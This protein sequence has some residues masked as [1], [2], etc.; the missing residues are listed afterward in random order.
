MCLKVLIAVPCAEPNNSM[1]GQFC[2]HCIV[3]NDAMCETGRENRP[4]EPVHVV[5]WKD[6]KKGT[7]VFA[8]SFCVY[9]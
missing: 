2:D 6:K 8:V 3:K 7:R 1:F 4:F 9:S 5:I